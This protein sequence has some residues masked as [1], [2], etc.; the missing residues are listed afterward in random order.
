MLEI[1][2]PSSN[3]IRREKVS[4]DARVDQSGE[5]SLKDVGTAACLPITRYMTVKQ[6]E[7]I[8]TSR[9]WESWA[10]IRPY[11]ITTKF[12]E[13]MLKDSDEH[14]D[15]NWDLDLDEDKIDKTNQINHFFFFSKRIKNYCFNCHS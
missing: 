13:Y 4:S 14:S 9:G 3:K 8:S 15:E 10:G 5:P 7:D 6:T 2:L 1:R 12:I 11:L